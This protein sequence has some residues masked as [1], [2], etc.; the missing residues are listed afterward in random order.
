MLLDSVLGKP[1]PVST[2][3]DW[4]WQHRLVNRNRLFSPLIVNINAYIPIH[5]HL[6]L[7]KWKLTSGMWVPANYRRRTV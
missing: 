4:P 5:I 1:L 7:G 6:G 3:P 2:S